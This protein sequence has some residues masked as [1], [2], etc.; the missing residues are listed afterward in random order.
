MTESFR[1]AFDGLRSAIRTERNMKVHL[2]MTIL[3]TVCAVIFDLTVTEKAAVFICCG[4]VIGA[5]LFNTAIETVVDICSPQ[6]SEDAKKTKD[7]AAAAVLAVSIISAV[8]GI[9]VFFPYTKVIID[10]IRQ[11]V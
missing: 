7:T 10:F 3:V 6:Y 8:V 11:L 5:E 4:L 9:I 1:H 2:V